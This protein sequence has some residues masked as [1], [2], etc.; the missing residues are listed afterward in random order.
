M[1]IIDGNG[2]FGAS[3]NDPMLAPLGIL[4]RTDGAIPGAAN[5][6]G[7]YYAAGSGKTFTSGNTIEIASV[8]PTKGRYLVIC[9]GFCSTGTATRIQSAFSGT[10]TFTFVLSPAG[11]WWPAMSGTSAS[12]CTLVGLVD[13]SVAGTLIFSAIATGG[14]S[15]S[16][17]SGNIVLIRL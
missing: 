3:A 6:G 5:I 8:S 17:G 4:G 13:I 9:T 15:S 14:S 11:D 12:K 10:S 1:T 7:S 2:I 16:D